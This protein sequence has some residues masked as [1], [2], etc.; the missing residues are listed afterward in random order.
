MRPCSHINSTPSRTSAGAP[1]KPVVGL[2]GFVV[3]APYLP[4]VG[5]CGCVPEA[6]THVAGSINSV[7]EAH[8]DR[9]PRSH[10]EG[11][12]LGSG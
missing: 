7:P 1:S 11:V 6:R 12:D 10:A 5:R 3:G 2:G 8:S 9:C 4:E